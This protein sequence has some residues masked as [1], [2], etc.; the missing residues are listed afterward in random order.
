ME[1][2]IHV[3]NHNH[4]D[5]KVLEVLNLLKSKIEIMGQKADEIKADTALINENLT[6]LSA[7]L[8]RIATQIEGGL[9]AEE[10]D[11]VVADVRSLA[12]RTKALADRNPEVVPPPPPIV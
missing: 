2:H 5:E 7:D 1:I 11:T 9:T 3:H 10:A 12:A 4:S 6:N 8:D